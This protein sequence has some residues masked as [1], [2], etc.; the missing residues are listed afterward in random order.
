MQRVR[1][2]RIGGFF[3]G[4]PL[5]VQPYLSQCFKSQVGSFQ[6][7]ETSFRFFL[8]QHPLDLGIDCAVDITPLNF[9]FRRACLDVAAFP[10]TIFAFAYIFSCKDFY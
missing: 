7:V 10:P 5:G 1:V 4:I 3:Y 8:N 2:M 9:S 6:I